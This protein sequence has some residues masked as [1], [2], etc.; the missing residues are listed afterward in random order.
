MTPC[1]VAAG[2]EGGAALQDSA[3]PSAGS[4]L[5]CTQSRGSTVHAPCWLRWYIPT[6]WH[7]S[8]ELPFTVHI[9]RDTYNTSDA[10]ALACSTWTL[11]CL[12]PFH[13]SLFCINYNRTSQQITA[14][15]DPNNYWLMNIGYSKGMS[16]T[17][18]NGL[19]SPSSSLPFP[20]S[21]P[22]S[23]S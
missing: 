2:A 12:S 1:G 19:F 22:L 13:V 17:S 14:D 6:G 23:S 7:V 21:P 16:A 5:V 3:P 10:F 15:L 20:S 18:H 11:P 8:V 4:A 9:S